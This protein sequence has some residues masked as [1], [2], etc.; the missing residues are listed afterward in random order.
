MISDK[1]KILVADDDEQVLRFITFALKK[2]GYDVI[3]FTNGSEALMHISSFKNKVDLILT[4]YILPDMNGKEFSQKANLLY[5]EIKLVFTSGY[6]DLFD[7]H[8]NNIQFI[9][10]PFSI[11]TLT[12]RI[13]HVL[14]YKGTPIISSTK[15]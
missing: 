8:E 2:D 12:E 14:D 11:Q 3:A 6:A 13:R 1:H 10:K 5:P 4:D 9:K 7:A 15:K